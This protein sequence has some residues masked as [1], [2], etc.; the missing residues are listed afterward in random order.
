MLGI[1]ADERTSLRSLQSCSEKLWHRN[2]IGRDDASQHGANEGHSCR[3]R[4][5]TGGD[6]VSEPQHAS[7]PYCQGNER[8]AEW[9]RSG[10]KGG[11]GSRFFREGRDERK[12]L[13][14][15]TTAEG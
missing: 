8:A 3:P 4:S 14:C 9:Q 12:R 11:G 6:K 1:P 2:T 5:R 15:T 7:P 13:K 10:W